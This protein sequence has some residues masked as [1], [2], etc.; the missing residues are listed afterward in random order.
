MMNNPIA[1]L[2]LEAK[3]H[4]DSEVV[5]HRIRSLI[6]SSGASSDEMEYTIGAVRAAMGLHLCNASDDS[7]GNR[8]RFCG[9]PRAEVGAILVSGE[10]SICD[11]CVILAVHTLSQRRHGIRFRIL[12]ALMRVLGLVTN[13]RPSVKPET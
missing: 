9:R 12:L 10:D 6:E 8:C 11:D 3:Q 5:V 13:T 4:N 2:I 7:V 1:D